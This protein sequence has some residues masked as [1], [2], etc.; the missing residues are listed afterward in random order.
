MSPL[1]Q[2]RS[3]ATGMQDPNKKECPMCQ[4][5]RQAITQPKQGGVKAVMEDKLDP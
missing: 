1:Q 5:E 2:R 3:Y 4:Q